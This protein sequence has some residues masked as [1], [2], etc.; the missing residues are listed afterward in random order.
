MELGVSLS[1]PFLASPAYSQAVARS[2]GAEASERSNPE[3]RREA[4]QPAILNPASA[5]AQRDEAARR[6]DPAAESAQAPGFVFDYEG[7]QRVMKVNNQKGALIYQVPSK[8]Q[9]AL[10]EAEEDRTDKVRLT[11]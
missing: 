1:T 6:R 7:N 3:G 4:S 9:L 11:A 10:I 8:G 5:E 2:G